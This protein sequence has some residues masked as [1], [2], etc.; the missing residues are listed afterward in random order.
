MIADLLTTPALSMSTDAASL[1]V[2]TGPS[3]VLLIPFLALLGA[4]LCGVYAALGVKTKAPAWTIVALLAASFAATVAMWLGFDGNPYTVKAF[5]WIQVRWGEGTGAAAFIAN[6]SFYVDTLTIYWMLFVTGLATLIA[7]YASEY[8]SHDVGT[9]YSRFFAAFSLFVFSMACLVMGDNFIMLYLGWEGV[10]LCSYLLIGYF[11]KK[12]SAVA[13][14][15]KAFIVNRIGDLGL[16][17]GIYLI[18]V[19]FGTVE[20][21]ALFADAK[22]QGY[23]EAAKVGNFDD[24]PAMAKA[25]PLLLMVGAFGKSAQFPLYVWL[26]DAMEGPTPVSALIHAATMVTAGVYLIARTYP[27]FLT[28]EIALPIVAWIGTITALL[29]AT[30]G[31]AQFDIKRIMAYSTVSQLGYMFAGLGVL[32]PTGAAYHTLTHAFFKALLFLCCGAVM[33][34]F[35]GQLDLRKLSGLRKVPGWRWVTIGML[36]GCLNLAGFPITAGYF[37]KDTILA[38][39]FVTPGASVIGFLLLLTAGLTAYYTFRV[40]FRVFMGPVHYEAGEEG[41]DH[42]HHDDHAHDTPGHHGDHE[43]EPHSV[44]SE[45]ASQGPEHTSSEEKHFAKHSP[46]PDKAKQHEFHPHAPGWA[47]NAVLI[48]LTAL[49]V[50][51]SGLYFVGGNKDLHTKHYAGTMIAQSTAAYDTPYDKYAFKGEHAVAQPGVGPRGVIAEPLTMP[52]IGGDPHKMMYFVS[53]VI[54]LVGIALAWWLHLA[55]RTTAAEC[56]MDKVARMFGPIPKW[57]EHK[58]YVDEFYHAVFRMPLVIVSHLSHWFDKLVIDGLVNLFGLLPRVLGGLIRPS[59]SGALQGY[60]AG[61]IGG[62]AVLLLVVLLIAAR[63]GGAA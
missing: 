48:T 56:R 60:A 31:M 25:I 46:A 51:A 19:H 36:V 42:E 1:S 12:P 18:F 4:A 3:W 41:H 24:I 54:G 57:A 47:I 27:L 17:L 15:K 38:E 9:G 21:A 29:A 32:T 13:A 14:A 2:G 39:A 10:G 35:A 6:F 16:A 33:H 26:P 44:E 30:I 5:D 62:A 43:S 50:L 52:I 58:W 28:S 7:L 34:G 8:M 59:Q 49:S 22:L 11:Y 40:F 53:G 55:G 20:F 63:I 23:L 37:S 45:P 61:M